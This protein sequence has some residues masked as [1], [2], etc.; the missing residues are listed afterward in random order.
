MPLYNTYIFR[1]HRNKRTR[2]SVCCVSVYTLHVKWLNINYFF[3]FDAFLFCF[4]SLSVGRSTSWGDIMLI[5]IIFLCAE[6]PRKITITQHQQCIDAL[7]PWHWFGRFKW[8]PGFFFVPQFSSIRR[9]PFILCIFV[10]CTQR[11]YQT[12]E[13]KK[14]YFSEF[15]FQGSGFFFSSEFWLWVI[16]RCTLPS[17]SR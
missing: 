9:W 4:F 10:A 14:Q 6:M 3:C 11:P 17:I 5:T 7:M 16:E 13:K 2:W 1:R 12:K 8:W 15:W